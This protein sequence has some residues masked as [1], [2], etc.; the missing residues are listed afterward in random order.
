MKKALKESFVDTGVGIV[1]NTPLNFA[2]ISI[3]FSLELSA[4]E[5]SM[6][7]TAFFTFFA[8]IRKTG[9]RMYFSKKDEQE[10]NNEN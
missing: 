10:K 4:F 6:L 9:T 8:I 5:T 1:I 7:L 2:L 3:A